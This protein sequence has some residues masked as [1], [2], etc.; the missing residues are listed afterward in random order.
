MALGQWNVAKLFLQ[1]KI[2]TLIQSR[3]STSCSSIASSV[4]YSA[5]VSSMKKIPT[6]S[7]AKT[8][9][10][11]SNENADLPGNRDVTGRFKKGQ[12]GNPSGRPKDVFGIAKL[13]RELSAEGIEELAKLMRDN[14]I[15]PQAKIAAINSILDRGLGKPMQPIQQQHLDENGQPTSPVFHVNVREYAEPRPAPK[16]NGGA[17]DASH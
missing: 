17:K 15:P 1:P 7:P 14:S 12:S 3:R 5:P 13:A 16:A 10:S 11:T 2:T 9:T 8:G 4:S 6:S